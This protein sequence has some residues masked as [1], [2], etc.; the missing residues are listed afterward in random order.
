MIGFVFPGQGSQK[1]GMGRAWVDT[2]PELFGAAS[3][4][5][6]RDLRA[7]V[8]DADDDTLRRTDNAQLATVVCSLAAWKLASDAGLTADATAGHSVGEYAAL[9]AAGVLGFADCLRLVTVRGAGMCDAAERFGGT[10][11]AVLGADLATVEEI[12]AAAGGVAVVANVNSESEI[13]VSGLETDVA[14]V[15]EIARERGIRKV[16]PI[17][18]G[19]A[20][21]SPLMAPALAPLAEALDRAE[22]ARPRFPVYLNV[23]AK[24]HVTDHGCAPALLAQLCSPV[25]WHESIG[26]MHAS[27]IDT[28]VVFG[29]GRQVAKILS[30]S[31]PDVTVVQLSEPDDL[32]QVLVAGRP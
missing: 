2:W 30:R 31:L 20:F 21:H 26:A 17:S 16:L 7:L 11:L 3:D 24:A 28:F 8:C 23:N 4:T 32:D 27:G 5:S 6:G 14:R 18:V 1:R 9:T 10:M 15:K 19:G 22:F 13:V 29:S 25:L 12:C